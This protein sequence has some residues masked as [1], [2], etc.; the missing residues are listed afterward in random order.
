MTET[1]HRRRLRED[2]RAR[3]RRRRAR[4]R[5]TSTQA[6]RDAL[7]AVEDANDRAWSGRRRER[8]APR[9]RGC[10]RE[11]ADLRD[12]SMRTLA[13][14]D[15]FRKRAERERQETRRYAARRA[16]A[17]LLGGGRQPRAGARRRR[18]G[19]RPQA[20]RRDDPP[21]DSQD[22]LRRHGV[23]E[24]AALGERFDPALHE[25]VRARR[26]R[27]STVAHR[28]RGAAARL[29]A[30]RPPAPA[31]DGA[32]GGAAGRRR[33]SRQSRPEPGSGYR[34]L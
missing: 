23:H 26:T 1:E 20:R 5:W 4:R 30:A 32:G 8:L 25:A 7:A 34:I 15:N 12:R 2:R 28:G 19:R 21:A 10:E 31:G 33:P 17:R 9:S 27:R 11:I 24:V 29:H 6:T 18:R 13:D 3:A 14:F 22:L 16:A